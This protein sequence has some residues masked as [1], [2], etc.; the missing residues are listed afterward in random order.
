MSP[1]TT[2]VAQ[3]QLQLVLQKP[4]SHNCGQCCV[5]ML[6]G[7][8]RKASCKVFGTKG[9]TTTKMVIRA[10]TKLGCVP[11]E[12]LKTFRSEASLPRTCML[13]LKYARRASGHWVVYQDGLIY[14][15]G[16]GIYPIAQLLAAA[17]G[18][19]CTSYLAVTFP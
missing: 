13:R 11:A 14:C 17:P 2:L 8:T 1:P 15:P 5:A 12:R 4:K 9:G 3:P 6:A 10:L 19:T 18:T 16:Q 7:V